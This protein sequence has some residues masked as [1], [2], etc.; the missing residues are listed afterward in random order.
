[1]TANNPVTGDVSVTIRIYDALT[2][3]TALWTETQEVTVTRGIFS[4]LLGS[5]TALDD[6]AFDVPYWY[7]VEVES[8]GPRR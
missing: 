5:T 8:D 6:L 3:G 4:M 1:M 2:G 7:S